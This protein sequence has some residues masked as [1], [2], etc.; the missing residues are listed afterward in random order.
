MSSA[1]SILAFNYGV[2]A[3]GAVTAT[4]FLNL[5][6]VSALLMSI[7]LGKPPS[8]NEL[9]GMAMVIGALLIH[10]ATSR[11]GYVPIRKPMAIHQNHNPCG[12]RP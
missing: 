1:I 9:V 12:V 2:R 11:S 10:T 3:L 5:V 4:A 8:A 6:P 7:A